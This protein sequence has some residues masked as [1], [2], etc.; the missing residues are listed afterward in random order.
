MEKATIVETF[1]V[2]GPKLTI[3][4]ASG[5]WWH[6]SSRRSL[7]RVVILALS[8]AGR[9]AEIQKLCNRVLRGPFYNISFCSICRAQGSGGLE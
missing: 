5:V 6:R 4:E 3:C 7:I 2:N 8:C 9:E 1:K